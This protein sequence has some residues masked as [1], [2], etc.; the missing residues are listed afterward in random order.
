MISKF[1]RQIAGAAVAIAAIGS[2]ALVAYADHSWG[3]YHWARTTSSFT[4]T[5]GDN[6]SSGWDSY[7]TQSSGD[8]SLS[9]VLDTV[10]AA[11]ATNPKNCRPVSGRA[12]VCNSKYGN[13]GWLGIA[14]IWVS[15]EHITQGTVKFNDTYFNTSKYNTP[16]W[17]QFVA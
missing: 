3:N 10:I 11:G 15:G 16:A 2:V 9:G 13:N 8:W 6:V 12:E 17:K 1:R 5:L 7:L 4:L 14:S